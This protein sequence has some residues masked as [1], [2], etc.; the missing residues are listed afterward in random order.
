MKR[1]TDGPVLSRTPDAQEATRIQRVIRKPPFEQTIDIVGQS[2]VQQIDR[3]GGCI[4][5][6]DPVGIVAI[7]IGDRALVVG[8]ELVENDGCIRSLKGEGQD[9][10]QEYAGF[11]HD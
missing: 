1:G 9:K 5:Q 6:L 11:S 4:V 3:R 8:H 10:Q 7:G 2:P